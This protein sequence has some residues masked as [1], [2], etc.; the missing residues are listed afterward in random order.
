MSKADKRKGFVL[1][2]DQIEQV[3]M[4]SDEEAGQLFKAL[5][6]CNSDKKP[7]P[8]FQNP[9]IQMCFSVIYAQMRRDAERYD[10]KCERMAENAKQ[11]WEAEDE[12]EQNDDSDAI[13]CN[14]KTK[15]EKNKKIN[16]AMVTDGV[17]ESGTETTDAADGGFSKAYLSAVLPPKDGWALYDEEQEEVE[18]LLQKGIPPTYITIRMERAREYARE[19]G[20]R[21]S[22]VFLEWWSKD[23]QTPTW[24][25]EDRAFRSMQKSA[26]KRAEDLMPDPFS[27]AIQR[28]ERLI[29]VNTQ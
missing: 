7:P 6:S 13:A 5:F 26:V 20:K 14:T 9:L 28:S 4:L 2:F 10:R 25:R 19:R 17:T 22:N 27:E 12:S 29:G 15:K 3:G 21:L 11:R 1:Y 18:L 24:K 23:K 16:I 8:S